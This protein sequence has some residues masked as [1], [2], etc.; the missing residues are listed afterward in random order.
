MPKPRLPQTEHYRLGDID[1]S[2][3]VFGSKVIGFYA[4]WTCLSCRC[5]G[6]AVADPQLPDLALGKAR[7]AMQSHHDSTH[8]NGSGS[9]DPTAGR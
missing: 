7:Q 9:L 1:Y 8:G 5:H 2:I 4:E 6:E 3:K